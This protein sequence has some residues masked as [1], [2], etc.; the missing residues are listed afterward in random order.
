MKKRIL[1]TNLKLAEYGGSEIDT[2]TLA[3][4]FCKM[5]YEVDVFTTKFDEP[6]INLFNK[7]KVRIITLDNICDLKSNYEYGWI[8][9]FPILDFLLINK[10]IKFDKIIYVSL[11]SFLNVEFVPS[12]YKNLNAVLVNSFETKEKLVDKNIDSEYLDIF[13]NYA[14]AKYFK[15]NNNKKTLK[16]IC[17]VSNHVPDELNKFKKIAEKSDLVVDI[18]GIT[19]IKK[20]IDE[21]VLNQYDLVISIGKTVNY[22]IALRIPVYCYDRFGG[23]GYI[24]KDNIERAYHYNFSGRGYDIKKSEEQ[25]LEDISNNYNDALKDIDYV[26]DFGLYNF[27][28]EKNIEKIISRV[29]NDKQCNIKEIIKQNSNISKLVEVFFEQIKHNESDINDYKNKCLCLEKLI[30]KVVNDYE[31]EIQRMIKENEKIKHDIINRY[32][33]EIRKLSKLE[34]R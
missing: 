5:N 31:I 11:S 4:Y 18:Y 30:E 1:L 8:H 21:K 7:I 23:P 13:P 17:I 28:F 16:K 26:R 9:H 22:A 3:K 25:L 2:F 29:D 14:P 12:Y 10:Q 33:K 27:C 15:I 19:G 32:D 6:M 20:I 34:K 24:N